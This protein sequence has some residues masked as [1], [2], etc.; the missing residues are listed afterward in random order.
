VARSIPEPSIPQP[1]SDGRIR[2]PSWGRLG[3]E[4]ITDLVGWVV[5]FGVLQAI[6][7]AALQKVTGPSLVWELLLVLVLFFAVTLVV[8]VGFILLARRTVR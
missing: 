4:V 7:T 8:R 3:L 6:G 5:V 2:Q 1:S